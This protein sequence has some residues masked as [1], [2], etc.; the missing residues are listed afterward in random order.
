LPSGRKKACR[1]DLPDPS[2]A[3]TTNRDD[4]IAVGAEGDLADRPTKIDRQA[5]HP[6]G[7]PALPRCGARAA[8]GGLCRELQRRAGNQPFY[9]G[10]HTAGWLVG[11]SYK[12]AWKVLK[13]LFVREGVLKLEAKG[14]L[15]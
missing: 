8:T 9:R 11:V 2:H 3:L 6:G 12:T 10:C 1:L 7:L 13:V 5:Q 14:S 4:V 15:E